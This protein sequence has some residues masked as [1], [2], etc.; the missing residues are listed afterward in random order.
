MMP[1]LSPKSLIS[2]SGSNQAVPKVDIHTLVKEGT[3]WHRC[4]LC[5]AVTLPQ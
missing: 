4:H 2:S 5:W 3:T 1:S